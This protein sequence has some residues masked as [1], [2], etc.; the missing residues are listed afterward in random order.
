MAKTAVLETVIALG[1]RDVPIRVYRNPRA[2][3]IILRVD[4]VGDDGD[5]IVLTLPRRTD[6]AEGLELA[7]EKRDWV[8]ERLERLAP[9]VPFSAGARIPL[10]GV[11]HEIRHRPDG[12]GG[13]WRDG[14][15]IV[16][17]GRPEHL[18]RRVRDWL[19]EQARS[20]IATRVQEK[21]C[22]LER[23]PGRITVRDT[24]SRWGSCSH[25]GNL[26]FCWRLVMAP[27][28]VLDYV[29]A[30]EVAHLRWNHHGP[31]FW[32]TVATLTADAEAARRWL[33]DHGERLHRYG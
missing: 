1:G 31:R 11:D 16:V 23:A 15:A 13:V 21:A 33:D 20:E 5:G 18:A 19:R 27:M 28:M 8:L 2:R 7:R 10:G 32:G 3:Q 25:D 26:S 29:V 17:S 4:G 22:L 24:R 6:L 14:F 12:R 9:R 30:H